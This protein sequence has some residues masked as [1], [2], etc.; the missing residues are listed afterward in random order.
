MLN[1]LWYFKAL[2]QNLFILFLIGEF[3][4]PFPAVRRSEGYIDNPFI[5]GYEF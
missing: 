5:V 3:C 1:V 2:W 4:N